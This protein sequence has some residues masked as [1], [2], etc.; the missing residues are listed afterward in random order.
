MKRMYFLILLMVLAVFA[1][2]VVF[3]FLSKAARTNQWTANEDV[4]IDNNKTLVLTSP[5]F[6][7]DQVYRS[8]KGPVSAHQ[9]RLA[10]GDSAL[11]WI[12]GYHVRAISANEKKTMPD[13][14]I[15]HNNLD[16]D[17]H[18]HYSRWNMTDRIN[19]TYPRLITMTQGQTSLS[20][21]AGFGFPV[22]TNEPLFITTQALNHNLKNADITLA[23]E[24]TINYVENSRRQPMKPLFERS[25]FIMLPFEEGYANSPGQN[26]KSCI[27]VDPNNH[28]YEDTS[29]GVFSGHWKISPGKHTYRY[30]ITKMM[31]LH[32][33]TTIHYIG[34]HTHPFSES[35]Q[36][37]H[38]EGDSVLFEATC[39]NFSD[40]VGLKHIDHYSSIEG[41][42]VFANQ[43]YELV[44]N[45]NNT[46]GE[47]QDMM[48]SMFL[49]FYDRE[50]DELLNTSP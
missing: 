29:G 13:D 11:V 15:C 23:H 34:V 2:G 1:G 10:S 14:F 36:L 20:F 25:V 50:M 44:S 37:R 46:S 33:N 28:R 18:A 30:D 7:I 40:K 3:H 22:F 39:A 43:H 48:A 9:F 47:N 42:P 32:V 24:V 4:A 38:V 45:V 6:A 17:L 12:S 26:T 16:F 31:D 41:L 5:L 35:L 8:M 19:H 27:P 49:Y 21:P